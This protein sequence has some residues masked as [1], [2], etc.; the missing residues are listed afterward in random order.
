MNNS[1]E[2]ESRGELMRSDRSYPVL[3]NPQSMEK[4][5]KLIDENLAGTK[6]SPLNLMRIKMPTGDGNEFKVEM[7]SGIE[8]HASI[9]CVITAFRQARAFWRK[10]YGTGR[11]NQPPDCTS[12]DGFTGEGDPGG[13]CTACPMA[14]FGSARAADGSQGAGQACKELRQLLVLLPGQQ[15]PHMLAVPPT[16]LS[17]FTKYSLGLIS[18]GRSYWTVTTRMT[19]EPAFN[20]GGIPYGKIRFTLYGDLNDRQ[21]EL[22]APYH[23]RMRDLL[24]PST[25]DAT[26]YEVIEAA[27]PEALRE[28]Q[29][30][31]E[32][33][34]IPF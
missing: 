25:V 28:A 6:I 3:A 29:R 21:A 15:L 14:A 12:K 32:D 9:T 1:N 27:P 26:A 16:S 24:T 18:G 17:N 11:G 5:L 19:V 33:D 22:L 2:E 7:A 10:P 23:Q 20:A 8:R 31:P 13:D 34:Q 30:P 4:I